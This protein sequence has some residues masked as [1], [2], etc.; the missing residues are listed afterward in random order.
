MNEAELRAIHLPGYA[1]A[2]KAGVGSI[3]VS[4]SSWNGQPMHG[5][6]RLITE[7]L[8]GELAFSGFVVT[9]WEA[10]NKMPGEYDKQV[11][12]AINAGIDMV[13]VPTN[14]RDFITTMKEL[15]AAGR[16]PMARIDDA[17]LRIVRQKARLGLWEAPLTDRT[18]DRADR[19][20]RAPSGRP[21]GGAREPGAAEERARR[22]AAVRARRA[23][24]WRA[25]R[26]TTSARNAEAGRWGGRAN[27]ARRRPAR[28]FSKAS[29]RRFHP[30]RRSRFRGTRPAP[31]RRPRTSTS[32]SSARNLTPKGRGDRAIPELTRAD[33]ELV[34]DLKRLGKPVVLILLT[35]APADHQRRVRQ[36][37]R[38]AGGLA[39]RAR[40]AAASPTSCSANGSRPE[41]SRTAGR[42]S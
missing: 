3:M 6:R 9:D 12:S 29:A 4:Y 16:I 21:P 34:A 2:V 24:T 37:R 33:E 30:G 28:R 25:P 14:F 40:K 32:S 18:A 39:A 5:N 38:R 8:K 20:R 23:S 19:F 11:E 27:A 26:R 10:I 13:M 42:A 15:V 22:A 35:G 7:V 1:A 36:R 41:N 17:V 31:R